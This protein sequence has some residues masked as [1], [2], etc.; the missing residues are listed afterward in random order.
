MVV[1]G[2]IIGRLIAAGRIFIR[3]NIPA[4]AIIAIDVVA[5]SR[6]KV[7]PVTDGG[8]IRAA[9]V[10]IVTIFIGKGQ[11]CRILGVAARKIIGKI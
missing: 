10:K 7:Q 6:R 1:Y 2:R 5:E 9:Q 4:A 11:T 8:G 3:P